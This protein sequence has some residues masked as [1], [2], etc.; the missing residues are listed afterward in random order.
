MG[1]IQK[2]AIRVTLLSYIGMFLGYFNKAFLFIIFLTTEEIGLLNLLL[3]VGLLFAQFCNLGAAFTVGKFFPFFRDKSK[4]NFGFLQYNLL[5]ITFGV[6][7]FT[8]LAYLFQPQISR[9]YAEKSPEFVQYY[10]WFIPIGIAYIYF[11]LFDYY[12]R[13]LFKNVI[14]VFLYEVVLRL[15]TM[16]AILAYGLDYINFDSL[17]KISALVYFIPTII[18]FIYLVYLKEIDL[19]NWRITISKKF[20]RILFRFSMLSYFNT[21]GSLIVTTID[22]I[23]I[24]SFLGLAETGIYTT[25]VFI[26]AFLQVPYRSLVRIS[27]PLVAVYWKAKDMVKM[28]ELYQQVSSVL[29]VVSTAL[30]L[31]VW[32]NRD[33]V[34]YILKPEFVAGIPV[35]LFIMIG[36]L[37]DMY[38]GINGTIFSMSKKYAYD[39]IFT[40]TLVILVYVLNLLLIPKMGMAGAAL[41][42]MLSLIVYNVGRAA[43]VWFQYKLHPFTKSQMLVLVIFTVNLVAYEFLPHLSNNWLDIIVRSGLL[44]ISYVGVLLVFKVEKEINAYLNKIW[45]K[46]KTV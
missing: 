4:N 17:I 20:R 10:T 16:V 7:L 1:I 44:S 34:F 42:T 3:S 29:L 40:F 15:V 25:V 46:F 28:K 27:T 11:L 33:A 21:L 19:F 5:I 38:M 8:A 26:T 22:A 36:R 6:V 41:G 2:D 12:L 39:L 30:F 45:R 24:A 43:F 13:A 14:S 31:Y 32:V 9:Y 18:A 23:M 35:F 37:T